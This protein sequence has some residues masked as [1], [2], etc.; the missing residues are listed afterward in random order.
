MDME[1][2][3]SMSARIRSRCGHQLAIIAAFAMSACHQPPP[4]LGDELPSSEKISIQ[5][6]NRNKLDVMIYFVHSGVQSRLGL[7]TAFTTT[8]FDLPL[9]S[10]G[11]GADYRLV[12]HPIGMRSIV[13]TETLHARVGDAVTWSLEDSFARSTVTVR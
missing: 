10:L 1:Q 6:E 12:G 8:A 9:G 2:R 7:A 5:V 3:K 11:A 13:T 4:K